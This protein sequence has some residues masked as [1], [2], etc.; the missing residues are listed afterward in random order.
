MAVAFRGTPPAGV[1]PFVHRAVGLQLLGLAAA[2]RAFY[3]VPSDHHNCPVGGYTHNIPLP[4][5]RAKELDGTLGLMGRAI[6]TWCSSRAGRA[7]LMLLLGAAGR[8]GVATQPGLAGRPTC[9]ALPVALVGGAV[10]ST[11]CI[12]NRVYTDLGEDELYVA[13]ARRDV[14]RV[15]AEMPT[16]L[17]ANDALADYHRERRRAPATE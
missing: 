3:T 5:E 1:A 10:A 15:A 7:R 2:G 4:A 9:M 11:G 17:A 13:V 16:I 8:A 6:P 12:S 14:A